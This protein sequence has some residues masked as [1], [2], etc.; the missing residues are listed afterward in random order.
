MFI[1]VIRFRIMNRIFRPLSRRTVPFLLCFPFFLCVLLSLAGCSEKKPPTPPTPPKNILIVLLDAASAKHFSEWGYARDTAPNLR[2][3]A[4][5]GTLFLNAHSQ[6]ANTTPS[7]WSFFTG[8]YPYIPGPGYTTHHFAENDA[9]MAEAFH[10]AGFRTGAVSENP[11]INSDY[12]WAKGF[13]HFKNVLSLYNPVQEKWSR[14]PASSQRVIDR[15]QEWIAQQ[16][17]ARWFCYVHLLRPHD[18]YDPPA[19]FARRFGEGLRPADHPRAEDKIRIAANADPASIT[20]DDREYMTGL[21]DANLR[22]ADSLIGEFM[23]WLEKSGLRENTLVIF[24]ADHGDAFMEHGVFG[25]N[26]TVYEEVT[27]VPLVVLA[28]KSAGFAKGRRT[29][30]VDLVDLL[31]TFSELFGLKPESATP[32]KSFLPALRGQTLPADAPA[33]SISQSAYDHYRFSLRRGPLKFIGAVDPEWRRIE[34]VE[35]Y[36]LSKDPLEK[37]NLAENAKLLAPLRAEAEKFLSGAEHRDTANDPVLSPDDEE[38][39][40]SIG[41]LGN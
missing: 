41:Y 20:R 12:G 31:P 24:M 22:Y 7:V 5:E 15:A 34:S 8:R 9:T 10:A 39:L 13:D 40:K 16:G 23:E 11:W 35:L 25:H 29:D 38:R 21:Y 36:D 27:N 4:R 1:S 30:L 6:A 14:D 17:D 3:L 19:R 33:P 26:T 28:P 18:P 32:G 2:K 37:N